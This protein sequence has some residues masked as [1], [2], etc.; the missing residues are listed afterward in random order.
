[1]VPIK[2]FGFEPYICGADVQSLNSILLIIIITHVSYF[3]VRT[4]IDDK[5]KPI[6]LN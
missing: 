1:M 2:D 3:G 6:Y 4:T 5:S